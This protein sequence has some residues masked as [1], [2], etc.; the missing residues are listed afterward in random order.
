MRR[1]IRM[2]DDLS[3]ESLAF[4]NNRAIAHK[5]VFETV[6]SFFSLAHR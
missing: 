6:F 3:Y 4:K 2:N 1:S 5:F